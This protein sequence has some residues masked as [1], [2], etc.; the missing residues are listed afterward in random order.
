M[1]GQEPGIHGPPDRREFRPPE[2]A[3][4]QG[5]GVRL[6]QGQGLAEG[7]TTVSLRGYR[8]GAGHGTLYNPD[9]L[10]KNSSTHEYP[11]ELKSLNIDH[12]IFD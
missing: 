1:C 11:N 4:S 12:I 3:P 7:A 6:R 2:G 9:D 8:P 5:Q 10:W